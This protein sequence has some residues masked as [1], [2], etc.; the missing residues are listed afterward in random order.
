MSESKPAPS[1]A[2]TGKP[3][4]PRDAALDV[5]IL[6]ATRR[7]LV[8]RGYSQLTIAE[9]AADAGVSRPTVYR[10][11]RTKFDLVSDALDYGLQAQEQKY[12]ESGDPLQ[13]A[14]KEAFFEAVRR[15]DPCWANPDAI[16]LQGNFIGETDRA[17]ELLAL[18]AEH[19]VNPRV[20]RLEEVLT[21]LR[22]DGHVRADVDIHTLA[23]MCFGA[24]FGAHLRGERDHAHLAEQVAASVWT[25]IAVTKNRRA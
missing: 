13:L 2:T 3:G 5:A 16:V 20:G 8:S 12:V 14:P 22:A 15:V 4:R 23:S 10:R 19:A 18:A 21:Q 6:V 24:F 9:V 17:P 7:H 25:L 11:W 1:D